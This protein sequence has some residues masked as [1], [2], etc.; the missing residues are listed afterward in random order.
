MNYLLFMSVIYVNDLPNV[1]KVMQFYLFADD[2]SVYYDSDN[3]INVQK[4]VNRELKK[5]FKWLDEN[6]LALNITNASIHLTGYHPPRAD[7]RATNFFRQ[8]PR[9]GDSF[10]VQNSGPPGRKKRNK[11][12]TPG[13]HLPS[14]NA[15]ISTK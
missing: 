4:N 14:S 3:V 11:I 2:T 12:S 10:S 9:P 1:S 8:N 5:I 15:K 6:K 13:H 7:C